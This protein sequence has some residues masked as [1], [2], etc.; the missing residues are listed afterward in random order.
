MDI[1][2]N[3]EEILINVSS[4]EVRAAYLENNILQEVY[5]E[6]QSNLSKINNIYKGKVKRIL[7][8]IQAAFIDIGLEKSAYLHVSD[9]KTNSYNKKNN[10]KLDIKHLLSEGENIMVQ[11]IKDPIGEKGARLSTKISIPSRY[12]VF[13]PKEVSIGISSKIKDDS[14]IKRL[15]KIVNSLLSE[16]SLEGGLIIRTIA[17]Q[18][19]SECIKTDLINVVNIWT[20]IKEQYNLINTKKLIYDDLL[21]PLRI[22]RDLTS[23][24]LNRILIDSE[25]VYESMLD[26]T[27]KNIRHKNFKLECYKGQENLFDLY[28]V[29][30]EI[31]KS[32]NKMISLES[33]G[34][35]IFDQT[36]AMNVIDVNTASFVGLNNSEETMYQTNLEAAVAIARQIR[37]RNLT[38]III[39][40]FIDMKNDIH[41]S[42]VLKLFKDSL[43]KDSAHHQI[44]PIS[45]LGLVEMTRK[46][47]RVGLKSVLSEDCPSCRG[48]GFVM[49]ADTVYFEI[50]RK[51][52][53]K[54]ENIDF[55]KLT[56]H[57]H[58]CV[59]DLFLY[60]KGSALK[61]LEKKIGIP[62]DLEVE[63]EFLQHQFDIN[64]A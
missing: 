55:N 31:Y 34:R 18:A 5:I 14:E 53:R 50:Y 9:I 47:T 42:N 19:T 13:M 36:E 25:S 64:L 3:K 29:E 62:I 61:E 7:P 30:E 60:N 43:A 27:K 35:V 22:L 59:I 21:L 16:N 2:E 8:G 20:K 1:D 6:R 52:L 51:I 56:I 37:L 26:F 44:M 32:M 38:G 11:V 15:Y 17:H 40:D 54:S 58:Q 4:S 39:I 48:L 12:L 10:Q 24:N 57:A 46:R 33:G 28:D 49:T 45:K 41:R 23:E 63:S